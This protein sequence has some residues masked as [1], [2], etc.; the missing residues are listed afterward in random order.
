MILRFPISTGETA[1]L[2]NLT[3]PKVADAVRRGL[4]SPPPPVRAG[5]RLWHRQHVRQAAAALGIELTDDLRAQL[6]EEVRHGS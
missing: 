3:E 1:H 4:V 6:Q 5:R 2:F